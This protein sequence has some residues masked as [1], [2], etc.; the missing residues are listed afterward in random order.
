LNFQL[1]VSDRSNSLITQRHQRIHAHGAARGNPARQ[2]RHS[3]E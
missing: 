2:Q 3:G 1:P